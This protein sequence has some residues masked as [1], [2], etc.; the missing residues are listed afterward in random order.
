MLSSA[1]SVTHTQNWDT[2]LPLQSVSVTELTLGWILWS[3]CTLLFLSLFLSLPPLST[4]SS[5]GAQMEPLQAKGSFSC[6]P[7][8]FAERN[9][10]QG[11]ERRKISMNISAVIGVQQR[12]QIDTDWSR[13]AKLNQ[14]SLKLVSTVKH[15]KRDC[16]STHRKHIYAHHV[17]YVRMWK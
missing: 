8:L 4:H 2:S 3:L 17:H 7:Y 14:R 6:A 5:F 10:P 15:D 9:P 16:I 1:F 13:V 12:K 11:K